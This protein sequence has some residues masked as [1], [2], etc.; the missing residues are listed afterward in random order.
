MVGQGTWK[1][2]MRAG[3]EGD[4]D[5]GE[6]N[7]RTVTAEGWKEVT[8]AKHF[9]VIALGHAPLGGAVKLVVI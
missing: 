3:R 7:A 6:A 8:M 2:G 4:E 1:S 9:D 5:E